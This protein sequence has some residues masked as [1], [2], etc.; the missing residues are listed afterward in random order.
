MR[1]DYRNPSAQQCYNFGRNH[2]SRRRGDAGQTSFFLL[3]RIKCDVGQRSEK[4][5]M[6]PPQIGFRMSQAIWNIRSSA[7]EKVY[8]IYYRL[9]QICINSS[10][11]NGLICIGAHLRQICAFPLRRACTRF[12][13]VECR[14]EYQKVGPRFFYHTFKREHLSN[15][16]Y[17]HN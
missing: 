6:G 15:H 3:F 17:S 4:Y 10:V 1:V 13:D 7:I 9:T 5:V 8:R 16:M 2:F 12:R 11:P 14:G